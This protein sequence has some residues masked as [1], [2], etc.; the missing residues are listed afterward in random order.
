M[1]N[2]RT[3]R[4]SQALVLL[5]LVAAHADQADVLR[6]EHAGGE[7]VERIVVLAEQ[8]GERHAVQAAGVAGAGRVAV[9]VRVDPDQAERARAARAPRRSRCRRRSCGR[10]RCTQ[11]RRPCAQRVGHRRGELAAQPADR[12]LLAPLARRGSRDRPGAAPARRRRAGAA[13][14]AAPAAPAPRAQPG[15]APPRPQAAPI[16]SICRCIATPGIRRPRRASAER[17]ATLLSKLVVRA[18]AASRSAR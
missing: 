1:K 6:L 2:T 3:P 17:G 5:G 14:A 18:S 12:E 9:H 8:P 7:P 13:R 10:R 16:S 4:R 15:S 11:G